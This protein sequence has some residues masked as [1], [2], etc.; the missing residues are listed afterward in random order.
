MKLSVKT[1]GFRELERALAEIERKAT[2]KA[3]MRRALVKAATPVAEMA[4]ALAPV[5]QTGNLKG[6]IG[7]ST[8]LSWR[9][10]KENRRLQA[11]GKAAVEIFIGPDY[12]KAGRHAHLVEFGT[13]PHV[14]AGKFPG[15]RHPGTAPQPFMRPA[16]DAEGRP[17][18]DR[19]G[20]EM[21]SEIEKAAARAA[22][23][24]ARAAAKAA[25]G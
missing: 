23:R 14:N 5:G 21:W 24:A 16:W 25:G 22:R 6:S 12:A 17:T 10:K 20:K 8:R 3:V 4:A 1:E 19:L 18:L 11:E 15:T 7:I 13:A 9:Q 2:A